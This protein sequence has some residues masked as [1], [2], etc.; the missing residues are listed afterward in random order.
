MGKSTFSLVRFDSW[1]G[2]LVLLRGGRTSLE[3]PHVSPTAEAG[4]SCT[5]EVRMLALLK[6]GEL[7]P[8]L[9]LLKQEF[10]H[11]LALKRFL[12]FFL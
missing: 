8:E 10:Q 11:T 12:F 2:E 3:E 5:A 1:D 7:V 9:V 6:Q 4:A